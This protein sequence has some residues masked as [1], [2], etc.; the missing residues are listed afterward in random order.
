MTPAIPHPRTNALR[1]LLEALPE[2]LGDAILITD[3][4]LLEM[5]GPRIVYVNQ[6]FERMTGWSFEDIIGQT[7][8]VLQGEATSRQTLDRLRANLEAGLA[9]EVELLNYRKDGTPFWVELTVAPVID[10]HGERSHWVSTQR[11]VTA[12]KRA[13]E[14]SEYLRQASLDLAAAASTDE[15]TRIIV[16]AAV[17]ALGVQSGALEVTSPTTSAYEGRGVTLRYSFA[18]PRTLDADELE[19]IQDLET[20]CRAALER[21]HAERAIRQSEQ[22]SRTII[23]ASPDCVKLLDIDGRLISMN[24]NGQRLLEIEDPGP[25]TG[26]SWTEFWPEET[27]ALVTAAVDSAR[28]GESRR[29]QAFGPTRKGTP[30][31]W[32]VIVTPVRDPHGRLTHVLSVSRDVTEAKRTEE[33]LVQLNQLHRRFVSDAAHE[34]RTPLTS[35]Q[36]NLGLLLRFPQMSAEERVET[37]SDA[38]S[39]A[40]RMGRL[41]TDMLAATR[42]GTR[43]ESYSPVELPTI[44]E[45]AWRVARKLSNWHAF[46]LGGLEALTVMGHSD[47]LKQLALILLENAVKYTP[48]GGAVRLESWRLG[49]RAL[50]SVTDSG[51]GIAATDLPHVFDRSYRADQTIPRESDPGGSGLGLAIAQ[52]IVEQHG[53]QISVSSELGVGTIVTVNL[54]LAEA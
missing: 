42:G 35:I 30:R 17:A 38:K 45:G 11:D 32:D 14:R 48:S 51:R 2:H 21:L 33:L 24:E 31:W 44:L 29:F 26:K 8:R 3:S 10:A 28:R 27:H 23:E 36:G 12:R 19:F 34:F 46:E 13:W 22:F 9:S 1:E 20:A 43:A 25:W 39:E 50:F 40:D 47:G 52:R 49:D 37:I 54:P 41:V 16:N 53:G 6:A 18:T 15:V 4:D 7:P 5:P